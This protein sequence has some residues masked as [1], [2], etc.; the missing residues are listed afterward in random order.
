[1]S[2][3]HRLVEYEIENQLIAGGRGQL[4]LSLQKRAKEK[5]IFLNI[6]RR[7]TR[8][9]CVYSG[10]LLSSTRLALRTRLAG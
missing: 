10:K 4:I 5:G 8:R 3:T 6:I 2:N 1:M 7:K 9:E